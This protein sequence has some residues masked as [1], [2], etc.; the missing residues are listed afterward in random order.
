MR[1]DDSNGRPKGQTPEF[2]G[3]GNFAHPSLEAAVRAGNAWIK[4]V[5]SLNEE[6]LSFSQEQLGKCVEAGQS[7]MRCASVE[8]AITAQCDIARNTLESCYREANK[9]ISM[10]GDIARQAMTSETQ[11]PSAT[12]GED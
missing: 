3:F 1:K 10:T 5:G 4:G 7:L 8:Q 11:G 9:L 12:A 6:M 2:L